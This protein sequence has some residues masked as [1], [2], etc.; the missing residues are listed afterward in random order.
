MITLPD[1][2]LQNLGTGPEGITPAELTQMVLD[3]IQKS[4]ARPPPAR[5]LILAKGRSI[6]RRDAANAASSNAVEKVN[7]G[8]GGFLKKK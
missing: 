1:I 4:A 7:K 3:A 5:W 6:S 2:H 8:I